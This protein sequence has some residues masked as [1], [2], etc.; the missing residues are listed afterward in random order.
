MSQR[1]PMVSQYYP[2]KPQHEQFGK[3]TS[4]SIPTIVRLFKSATTKQINL[5][6]N[7]PGIPVWQRGYYEHII[8]DEKSLFRIRQYIRA[9]PV[10]WKFDCEN[11]AVQ[12]R[13]FQETE[14]CCIVGAGSEPAP[15]THQ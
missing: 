4:N 13:V 12:T 8:R 5:F 9:N 6:R 11:P 3:P 2:E 7:T 1:T 15:T 10:R 14:Y